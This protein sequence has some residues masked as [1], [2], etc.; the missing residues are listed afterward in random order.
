MAAAGASGITASSVAHVLTYSPIVKR[1]GQSRWALVA[2]ARIPVGDD[3]AASVRGVAFEW[4]SGSL[5]LSG[6]IPVPATDRFP[7][8]RPA[9]AYLLAG[10]YDRTTGDGPPVSLS[11]ADGAVTGIRKVLLATGANPGERIVLTF[12]ILERSWHG[13]LDR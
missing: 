2:G 3:P 9:L 8:P 4:A 6:T 1:V 12:D 10:T 13:G 5:R 11:V 7:I